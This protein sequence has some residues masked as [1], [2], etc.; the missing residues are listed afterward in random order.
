MAANSPNVLLIL[1]DDM[2]FSDLGCYGGEIETPHLD[3]L[4]SNGLR[5]TQFYNTA[6]CCPSRASLLTG[7]H[8]HQA[9]VGHMIGNDDIDGYL[10]DLSR[11]AATI[12]EVLQPAGYGTYM[13]GKWHVTGYY[14]E[15]RPDNWPCQRGFDEYYGMLCGA[16]SYF[17]PKTMR[18]NNTPIEAPQGDFYFTDALSDEAVEQLRGHFSRTPEKPFFQYLAYTAP[19]WPLHAREEDMAKYRGRYDGGWDH[20][21]EERLERLRSLGILEEESS[22]SPRDASQEP[23]EEVSDNTW[24]ARRMEVYAAMI[25]RM[26]QG[27]GRVLTFLEE[28][29]ELDNTLVLFL[30]DNGGCHE[31][32]H[33][34]T[35]WVDRL[36]KGISAQSHT[37]N[38]RPV[39]FGNSPD[40]MPGPEDT[41]ASY[42][43]PWANVSNTPF[44]KYKSW[45]YEGGISTPLIVHWPEGLA[46]KGELRRQPAQ[47]PD[48]MAT[49]LEVTGAA[50]PETIGDRNILP[51]EG[52]SL[53]PTFLN[54]P[55]QR[56]ILAWEHEGKA[57]LRKGRWKIVRDFY[58]QLTAGQEAAGCA[59]G[60]QPWE[61]Y[62]LESDRSELHDLAAEKPEQVR[63]LAAEYASWAQRCGVQ[64][65]ET[66]LRK[67]GQW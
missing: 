1:N 63:I 24:Q 38:G 46:A 9:D 54:Q 27:I 44:R 43:I 4:A 57:G 45:I 31:E 55:H 23:W 37:R 59:R 64:P 65:W 17:A 2:G 18:R 15:N 60:E 8:P 35:P 66:I 16:A 3:R 28:K 11:R 34:G 22:L 26:D 42:G 49:V 56:E 41:Y 53:V 25:D 58:L 67:R 47:L 21:R 32:I 52:V 39:R 40:I 6:R 33:P 29:G 13:S 12:A 48:I 10:G 62:D 36:R 14:E 50:Y 7:L 30:S 5:Y 61:L 51:L 19:H 20:L